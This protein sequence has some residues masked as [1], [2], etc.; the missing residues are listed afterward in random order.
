[1]APLPKTLP[2]LIDQLGRTFSPFERLKILT[3]TWALLRRMTPEERLVVAAQLGLDHADDLVEALAERRG[4]TPPATLLSLIETAQVK[5]TA[6]LPKL[7]ADLRDPKRRSERLT[8]GALRAVEATLAGGVAAPTPPPPPPQKAAAPPPARTDTD[9]HGGTS[10]APPPPPPP[11]PALASAALP[12]APA[13]AEPSVPPAPVAAPSAEPAPPPPAPPAVPVTA[14]PAKGDEAFAGRLAATPSVLAR[15][16]LFRDSLEGSKRPPTGDLHA[17]LDAFPDGW[18]RRRALAALL[19]AGLPEKAADAVPL[20]GVLSSERDR[21]W[22]LG[23]LADYRRLS[24]ADRE[25]L[26]A[27]IASP[28]ARRRLERRFIDL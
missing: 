21:L 4:G 18:V 17:L 28:A 27:T 23:A 1:M 3:R 5:G 24:E 19:Q 12:Q 15:L 11:E 13:P 9:D 2:E 22:C 20:L 16:R 10:P 25:S 14:K 7:V 8:E 6:H 26:L